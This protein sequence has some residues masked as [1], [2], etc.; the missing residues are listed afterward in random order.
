MP[1]T[2]QAEINAGERFAFGENWQRF[3]F[4]LDESR[5]LRAEDSLRRMLEVSDLRGKTFL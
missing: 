2:S 1:A 4:T 3:L 5:I